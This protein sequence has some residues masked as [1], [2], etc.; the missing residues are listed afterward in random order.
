MGVRGER[1]GARPA[2]FHRSVFC[3]ADPDGPEPAGTAAG[4]SLE[5]V[6][7]P[8]PAYCYEGC[9]G[10]RPAACFHAPSNGGGLVGLPTSPPP[11]GPSPDR[12]ADVT[13]YVSRNA[14]TGQPWRP[15]TSSGSQE[16][17]QVKANPPLFNYVW[18]QM[19]ERQA[20]ESRPR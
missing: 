5:R 11:N 19:F 9:A 2:R 10:G 14:T 18:R 1:P 7:V 12:G 15:G 3:R 17:A 8:P 13:I 20:R 6:D 4:H 16:P